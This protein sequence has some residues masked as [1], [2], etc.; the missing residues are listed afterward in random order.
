VQRLDE[1]R[2]IRNSVMHFHPDRIT[3]QQRQ[4]LA[5]TREMLQGL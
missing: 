1:I 3:P 4:V 5:Q 2:T